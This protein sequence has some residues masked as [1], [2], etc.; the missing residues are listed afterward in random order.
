MNCLFIRAFENLLFYFFL[1]TLFL[2]LML[3]C[4]DAWG[5][6]LTAR[7]CRGGDSAFII[8]TL[9]PTFKTPSPNPIPA[10]GLG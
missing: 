5:K 10:Q 9:P 1:F 7:K 6:K 4:R 2:I 8:N 3:A